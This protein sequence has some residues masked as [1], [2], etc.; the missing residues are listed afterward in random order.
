VLVDH[1]LEPPN[2]IVSI[3]EVEA[4][5]KAP[6]VIQEL[7]LVLPALD[8]VVGTPLP[9]FPNLQHGARRLSSVR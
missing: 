1:D 3:M 8:F 4:A 9:D 7:V 2:E 6:L 5:S